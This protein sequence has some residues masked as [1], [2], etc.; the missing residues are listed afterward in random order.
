VAGLTVQHASMLGS[1]VHPLYIGSFK[2]HSC[3]LGMVPKMNAIKKTSRICHTTV[4][5]PN[6][7]EVRENPTNRSITS[8][9]VWYWRTAAWSP[10]SWSAPP[11]PI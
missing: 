11:L 6:S 5:K 7:V 10:S 4:W 1:T 9:P 2:P 8:L 3:D